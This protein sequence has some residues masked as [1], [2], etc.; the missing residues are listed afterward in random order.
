MEMDRQTL[1]EDVL[2]PGDEL[3]AWLDDWTDVPLRIVEV[4]ADR[5]TVVTAAAAVG[6]VDTL[7]LGVRRGMRLALTFTVT[8]RRSAGDGMELDVLDLDLLRSVDLSAR[9]HERHDEQ[10]R[11]V[12]LAASLTDVRPTVP[13][14]LLDRSRSGV[15]FGAGDTLRTGDRVVLRDGDQQLEVTVVRRVPRAFGRAEYGCELVGRGEVA[16][17]AG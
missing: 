5:V 6:S 11:A 17:A 4:G 1:P 10:G 13:V 8:G 15:R 3:V 9:R 2:R 16:V 12:R 14:R 7:H